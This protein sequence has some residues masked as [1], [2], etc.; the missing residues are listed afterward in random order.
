MKT[1]VEQLEKNEVMLKVE[2]PVEDFDRAI[3]MAFKKV[4]EKVSIP[5]F[6][7][8]KVP[9]SI[10]EQRVGKEYVIQEALQDNLPYLYAQAV[11]ESGIEPIDQ[12]EV[13]VE[14]AQEGQPLI[15]KAKVQVKPEVKVGQFEGMEIERPFDQVTE[16]DLDRQVN[17]VRESF[18]TLEEAPE[19]K[20]QKGHNVIIDFKGTVDDEP[21]EGGSADDYL[22][23][24]GSGAFVPGVEDQ[25]VGMT[26]GETKDIWVDIPEEYHV[27]EIAGKHVKFVVTVREIKTKKLPEVNDELAKGLGFE[28][29]DEYREDLKKKLGAMKEG[30]ADVAVRNAIVKKVTDEADIDIPPAM[31]DRKLDEM[32]AEFASG[33]QGRGVSLEEY[34]EASSKSLEDLKETLRDEAAFQVKSSLVLEEISKQANIDLMDEEIDAEIKQLADATGRDFDELKKMLIASGRVGILVERIMSKKTI[35]WLLDKANIKAQEKPKGK[36]KAAAKQGAAKKPAA[37]KTKVQEAG[38]ESTKE[39]PAGDERD[40]E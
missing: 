22:L 38:E 34:L 16:E 8:G 32:I 40:E 11:N 35:D 3:G 4:A 6:R 33:I 30:S 25:L 9:R 21:I 24:V 23:E 31:V 10:V 19:A 12:P 1:E 5:G 7:K 13:D 39:E 29:L 37:K 2:V 28:T 36:G 18:G 20:V 17:Q 15:F 27:K 26:K 14:Q